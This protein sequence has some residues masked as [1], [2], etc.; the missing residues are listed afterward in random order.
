MM[1]LKILL[2]FLT[3]FT[4]PKDIPHYINNPSPTA[5]SKNREK[6]CFST[7]NLGW[8][9]AVAADGTTMNLQTHALCV[10]SVISTSV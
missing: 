4:R 7:S 10:Q 3:V 1:Y 5:E 8:F 6:K 9:S 2:L